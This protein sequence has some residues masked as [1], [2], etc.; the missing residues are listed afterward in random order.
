MDS[1]DLGRRGIDEIHRAG[2]YD[3]SCQNGRDPDAPAGP[4]PGGAAPRTARIRITH[5]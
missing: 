2:M 4:H 1:I 3:E 5:K